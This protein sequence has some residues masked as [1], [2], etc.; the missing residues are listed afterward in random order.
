MR[1]AG[2]KVARGD[3]LNEAFESVRYFV[4]RLEIASN[5]FIEQHDHLLLWEARI[6]I[7]LRFRVIEVI[8]RFEIVRFVRA[9]LLGFFGTLHVFSSQRELTAIVHKS[10]L[11]IIIGLKINF[12]KIFR[13]P[14][15]F[16]FL[17]RILAG[18]LIGTY[19]QL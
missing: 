1:E 9:W 2:T 13:N 8:V 12:Q 15:T 14:L 10:L 19:R 6:F 5:F 17:L 7:W 3:G 16:P 4:G 18:S 11:C